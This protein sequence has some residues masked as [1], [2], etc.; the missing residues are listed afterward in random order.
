MKRNCKH[1]VSERFKYNTARE[2]CLQHKNIRFQ[3]LNKGANSYHPLLE[4]S[5]AHPDVPSQDEERRG[6]EQCVFNNSSG[7]AHTKYAKVKSNRQHS[8]LKY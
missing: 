5:F 6:G 1:W 2:R 7:L 8:A 3:V 4:A